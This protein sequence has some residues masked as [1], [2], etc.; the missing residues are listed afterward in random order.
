MKYFLRIYLLTLT[1]SG[2]AQQPWQINAPSDFAWKHV[3]NPQFASCDG[4]PC[5]AFSPSGQPYVA[6]GNGSTGE[7]MVMK[8]DG[9]A[10]VNVG[11]PNFTPNSTAGL[12]LAFDPVNG[13]PYVAFTDFASTG[14]RTSVMKF[15]GS[16][17]TFVGS[18]FFS[19]AGQTESQS[20]AF[21][22]ADNKP[23]VAFQDGG[24][25]YNTRVMRFNGTDWVN[26]GTPGFSLNGAELTCL[27]FSPADS[28]PYVSFSAN[29]SS[30]VPKATVM[31]FNGTEWVYVGNPCFSAHKSQRLQL[32][33]SP[34]NQQP[35][36]SFAD[37]TFPGKVTVMTFTG[38]TWEV[39]GSPQFSAGYTGPASIALGPDGTPYVSFMDYS[40]FKTASVMKFDGTDWVYVGNPS[41]S[42]DVVY[43]TSLAISPSGQPFL[44]YDINFVKISVLSYDSVMTGIDEPGPSGVL[45]YPNPTADVITVKI[46]SGQVPCSLSVLDPNGCEVLTCSLNVPETQIDVSHLHSGVYF[47]RLKTKSKVLS[48]KFVKL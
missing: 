16:N 27:A 10:W 2:L 35:Y 32:A 48:E 15:D 12:S 17:W 19:A 29:D 46:P 40:L 9:S 14:L 31:K 45:V 30:N 4:G 34:V 20:L 3:G 26:V 44:A 1:V 28:L 47:I 5:L 33:F 8:F 41:I 36:V 7:A 43:Y 42:Q 25:G 38:T 37:V 11:P 21:S 23:Y 18:E 24:W 13:E 39:V 22:P 6:F